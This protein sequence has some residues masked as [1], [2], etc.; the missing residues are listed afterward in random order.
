MSRIVRTSEPNV[1]FHEDAGYLFPPKQSNLAP[2]LLIARC[3]TLGLRANGTLVRLHRP[4]EWSAG[5]H[6]M[7]GEWSEIEMNFRGLTWDED[8]TKTLLEQTESMLL[9]PEKSLSQETLA[10]ACLVWAQAHIVSLMPFK[11]AQLRIEELQEA[12]EDVKKKNINLK[13]AL[14]KSKNS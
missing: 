14:T 6:G 3:G 4:E 5:M 7:Y 11:K 9:L 1:F 8:R 12:I 2:V 13:A 10:I